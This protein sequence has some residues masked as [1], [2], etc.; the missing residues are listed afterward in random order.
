MRIYTDEELQDTENWHDYELGEYFEDGSED[1]VDVSKKAVRVTGCD[2]DSNL[3]ALIDTICASVWHVS[4][5]QFTKILGCEELQSEFGEI[6]LSPRTFDL[7]EGFSVDELIDACKKYK[8][9]YASS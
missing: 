9:K 6:V 4:V 5:K 8:E 7:K 2:E 1:W 3:Q